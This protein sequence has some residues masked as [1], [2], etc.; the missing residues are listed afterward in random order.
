MISLALK[1]SGFLWTIAVDVLMSFGRIEH[2]ISIVMVLLC[3]W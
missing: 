2:A 1:K 3:L